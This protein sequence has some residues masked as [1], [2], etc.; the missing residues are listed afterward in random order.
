MRAV[1]ATQPGF[2][3]CYR[4]AGEVFEIADPAKEKRKGEA[5]EIT[6]DPFSKN[7]MELVDD[8]KPAKPEKAEKAEKPAK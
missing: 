1:R 8:E 2:Y 7:W 6:V 4:E 5:G 3:G